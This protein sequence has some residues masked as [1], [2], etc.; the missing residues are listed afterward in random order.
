MAH[1][2]ADNLLTSVVRAWDREKSIYIA[3]AMNTLMFEHPA[4]HEHLAKLN[5]W[6]YKLR[7]IN[8]VSK[9]LA[10]GDSGLGAMAP[11]E[12]IVKTLI[13]VRNGSQAKPGW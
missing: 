2:M 10:C 7:V 11:I 13:E 6:Y 8:P 1:G 9:V 3:P 4:T 12:E 5:E